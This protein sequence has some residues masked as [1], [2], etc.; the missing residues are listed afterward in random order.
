M[1]VDY[2]LVFVDGGIKY[3]VI[4]CEVKCVIVVNKVD[5]EFVKK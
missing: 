1:N 4:F 5:V 2:E 3:N